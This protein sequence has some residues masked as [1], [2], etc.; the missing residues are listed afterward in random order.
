[1]SM[2]PASPTVKPRIPGR[3]I[4]A[5]LRMRAERP[6]LA[7][8]LEKAAVLAAD[9]GA[10]NVKASQYR[11]TPHTCHCPD[12]LFKGRARGSL[13]VCKHSLAVRLLQAASR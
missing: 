4:A 1:M 11:T 2:H 3:M 9:L 13:S 6:D 5:A 8:R 10:L 7:A 12:A